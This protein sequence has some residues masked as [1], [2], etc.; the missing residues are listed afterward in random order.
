MNRFER[1][2][3][4]VELKSLSDQGTKTGRDGRESVPIIRS[5][6]CGWQLQDFLQLFSD[7]DQRQNLGLNIR[8]AHPSRMSPVL[9]DSQPFLTLILPLRRQL[10]FPTL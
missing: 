9:Y 1:P 10:H 7:D 6:H 8:Q 5:S 2:E 3:I 4:E